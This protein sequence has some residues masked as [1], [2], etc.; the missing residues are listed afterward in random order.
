MQMSINKVS[1]FNINP[2]VT[3]SSTHVCTTRECTTSL[4]YLELVQFLKLPLIRVLNI[5]YINMWLN[6]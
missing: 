2:S 4:P 6:K 1:N 3:R 5:K